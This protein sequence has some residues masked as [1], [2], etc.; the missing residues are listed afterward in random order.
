[1]KLVKVLK[2]FVGTPDEKAQWGNQMTGIIE[3]V[4]YT[5]PWSRQTCPTKGPSQVRFGR[6]I[7][8]EDARADELA[9][10]GVVEILPSPAPSTEG[11]PETEQT[12]ELS[13]EPSPASVRHEQREQRRKQSKGEA[14]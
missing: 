11:T 1:M 3:N 7:T 12:P 2:S 13:T 14:K 9:K 10:L 4:E 5:V 6:Q 8:L